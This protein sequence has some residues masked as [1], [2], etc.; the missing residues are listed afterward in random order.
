MAI[1]KINKAIVG[2]YSFV[3]SPDYLVIE[4]SAGDELVVLSQQDAHDIVEWL[5]TEGL[6]IC[7]DNK[8]DEKTLKKLEN[9]PPS[10]PLKPSLPAGPGFEA[11]D[12]AATSPVKAGSSVRAGV[13][14]HAHVPMLALKPGSRS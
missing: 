2:E 10:E 4:N 9:L 5:V 13:E 3:S 11:V 6:F 12:L 8:F 1:R 14:A 7:V